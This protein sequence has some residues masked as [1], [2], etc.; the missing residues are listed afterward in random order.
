LVS[1]TPI[2]FSDRRVREF[3]EDETGKNRAFLGVSN[4]MTQMQ[5]MLKNFTDEDW[6]SSRNPTV[7]IK[8]DLSGISKVGGSDFATVIK[9]EIE[10]LRKKRDEMMPRWWKDK[11]VKSA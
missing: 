8:I 1:K 5:Y 7:A 4:N 6:D 10:E 11:T 3:T 9:G 2:D